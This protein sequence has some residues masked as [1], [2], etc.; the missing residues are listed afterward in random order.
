[1]IRYLLS[2][3]EKLEAAIKKRSMELSR[4]AD[5]QALEYARELLKV[6]RSDSEDFCCEDSLKDFEYTAAWLASEHRDDQ[7]IV[8]MVLLDG[9]RN[10]AAWELL[11]E[12][13]EGRRCY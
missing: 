10:E 3:P 7:R 9:Y 2:L 6:L 1:M 13:T 11:F 4:E 5:R 8:N 12:G